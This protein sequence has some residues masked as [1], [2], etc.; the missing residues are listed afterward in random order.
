MS[1]L[2][3]VNS[4]D[5]SAWCSLTPATKHLIDLIGMNPRP[6]RLTPYE[7]ELLLQ[8]KREL[9]EQAFATPTDAST[10]KLVPAV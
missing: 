8:S 6:R 9:A 2:A 10:H 5:P 4:N 7:I 1:N 3:P